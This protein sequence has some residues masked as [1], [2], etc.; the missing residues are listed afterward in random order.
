LHRFVLSS[1]SAWRR[2]RPAASLPAN[3][4]EETP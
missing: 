3:V 2:W 4:N 1:L